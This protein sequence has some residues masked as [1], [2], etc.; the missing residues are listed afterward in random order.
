MAKV[1]TNPGPLEFTATIHRNGDVSNSSAFIPFPY[2]LKETFGVGNLIPIKTTFDGRVQYQGS[3]AKMGGPQT[4]LLLRKD[5]RTELGKAPGDNVTVRVVLDDKPRTLP[6]GADIKKALQ[7]AGQWELFDKLAFS[8]RCEYVRWVD[9]AKK[10]RNQ[11]KSYR[12]NDPDVS[13]GQKDAALSSI[14]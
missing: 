8:H 2:D 1:Y 9:D 14:C 4:R 11:G 3:L 5:V 13:C 6:V 10:T 12:K 7:Q